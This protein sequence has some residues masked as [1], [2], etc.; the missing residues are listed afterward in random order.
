MTTIVRRISSEFQLAL[1]VAITVVGCTPPADNVGDSG[2]SGDSG[3]LGGVDGAGAA[4]LVDNELVLS[5]AS[6]REG[7]ILKTVVTDGNGDVQFDLE[8]GRERV[9]FLRHRDNTEAELEFPEPLTD[10]PSEAAADALGRFLAAQDYEASLAERGRIIDNPG[11]DWVPNDPA[12]MVRCCAAHDECYYNDD[13]SALSWITG[14][15]D[16]D[17]YLCNV[18]AILCILSRCPFSEG[19]P[20]EIGCFDAACGA[21]Y[22]CPSLDC[23]ECE[24]PCVGDDSTCEGSENVRHISSSASWDMGVGSF[25]TGQDLLGDKAFVEGE[26]FRVPEVFTDELPC[27]D[28]LSYSTAGRLEIIGM[29]TSPC[30]GQIAMNYDRELSTLPFSGIGALGGADYCRAPGRSVQISIFY[31]VEL[32]PWQTLHL[33]SSYD[34]RTDK[35]AMIDQLNIHVADFDI[36]YVNGLTSGCTF[37][38]GQSPYTEEFCVEGSDSVER[39]WAYADFGGG[40]VDEPITVHITVSF[41]TSAYPTE[42][43]QSSNLAQWQISV[44]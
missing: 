28:D 38:P 10:L 13:C 11:C 7:E 1:I 39:E 8:V 26:L 14:P 42:P 35:T 19:D 21:G 34:H 29:N 23:D 41:V 17:C 15:L 9:I 16:F 2:G 18:Q 20:D 3:D 43:S 25:G 30:S 37:G 5:V 32:F 36:R 44:R 31:E 22:A 6:S 12:C 40:S 33:D 4:Q 27:S 24:S